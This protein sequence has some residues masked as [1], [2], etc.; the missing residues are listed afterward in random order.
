MFIK[1][2]INLLLL[3]LLSLVLLIISSCQVDHFSN[4]QEEVFDELESESIDHDLLSIKFASND[5]NTY[6]GKD[7]ASILATFGQPDSMDTI[8]GS[9]YWN[10][11]YSKRTIYL[12]FLDDGNYD[13]SGEPTVDDCGIVIAISSANEA[14]ECLG[15]KIGMDYPTI[16]AILG[17]ST[18]NFLLSDNYPDVVPEHDYATIVYSSADIEVLPLNKNESEIYRMS[19]VQ[20]SFI[21]PDIESP[22]SSIFINWKGFYDSY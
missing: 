10:Y 21:A 2:N 3:S 5:L 13:W 19:G 14:D 1:R 11:T 18:E 9:I 20:L 16:K 15:V 12:S 7:A 17:R 6:I 8:G 22:I 4:N